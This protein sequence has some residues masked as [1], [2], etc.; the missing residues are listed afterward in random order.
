MTSIFQIDEHNDMWK[1]LPGGVYIL[2]KH[3]YSASEAK[4]VL[5]VSIAS[6]ISVLAIVSLLIGISVSLLRSWHRAPTDKKCKDTRHAFIKSHAGIYFISMMLTTLTFTV[7]FML[8]IVWAVKR[9]I[10]FGTFCTFQAALKQFGNV[11]TALWVLAIAVHTFLVVFLQIQVKNWVFYIIFVT[12]W[13]L[14]GVIV[15][16]G[17][18]LYRRDEKGP[19]YG[20]SAQW[21]WTSDAYVV[22]RFTTEYFWMFLAAGASFILYT[23][24][25]LKLRGHISSEF[26]FS[27]KARPLGPDTTRVARQMLWY[28]VVYTVLV[29]PIAGCRIYEIKTLE[30][31]NMD[32][33]FASAVLF[34]LSGLA[35]VVLYGL[36]RN[37][38]PLPRFMCR[39]IHC[40]N[41]SHGHPVDDE[42]SEPS[43]AGRFHRFSSEK[44]PSMPTF[45]NVAH[46]GTSPNPSRLRGP[47]S[48]AGSSLHRTGSKASQLS[49][50]SSNSAFDARPVEIA[51]PMEA[52]LQHLDSK[53][54][55]LGRSGGL[56]K[57]N[58]I[59]SISSRLS[60]SSISSNRHVGED[61][62]GRRVIKKPNRAMVSPGL[63]RPTSGGSVSV[64]GDDGLKRGEMQ[65]SLSPEV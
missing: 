63:Q 28:P 36:T 48:V 3:H 31:S 34:M 60:A 29:F 52:H 10:T 46:T 51:Q 33:K 22:P 44:S 18:I 47:P 30:H 40:Q 4:G 53:D 41:R 2:F 42:E 12:V 54:P 58:S 27:F 6:M 11:A 9:E 23:L 16:A 65:R 62:N 19:W 15:A 21:C 45:S 32:F 64:K 20:I 38:F 24:L 1:M 13:A 35:N 25:F 43:K 49:T 39:F 17:P 59:L 37:I 14:S 56:S 7:G 5:A 8:S 61:R 50:E 57:S 26:R 55:V